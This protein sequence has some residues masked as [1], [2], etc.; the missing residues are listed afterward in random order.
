[1][2]APAPAPAVSLAPLGPIALVEEPVVCVVGVGEGEWWKVNRGS[3]Q[4]SEENRE[5]GVG[6]GDERIIFGHVNPQFAF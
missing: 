1:M 3:T 4:R 5:F 6:E 2:D